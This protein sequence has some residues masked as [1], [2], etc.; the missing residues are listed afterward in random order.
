MIQTIMI[1][2]DIKNEFDGSDRSQIAVVWT[3]QCHSVRVYYSIM[4]VE[5]CLMH[6]NG[7]TQTCM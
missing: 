7:I 1:I 4:Y 5:R 6:C 2:V 3:S